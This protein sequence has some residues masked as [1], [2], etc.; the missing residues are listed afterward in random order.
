MISMMINKRGFTL[1][2]LLI[3]IALISILSVA[4]LATINPI[5]QANKAKGGKLKIREIKRTI[6]KILTIKQEKVK[7]RTEASKRNE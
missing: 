4:V 2:E 5:E 3:V 1:V 7:Q 6:A